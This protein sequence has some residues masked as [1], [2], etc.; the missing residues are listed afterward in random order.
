MSSVFVDWDD[1][2]AKPTPT[3][4]YSSVFDSAVPTVDR[5]DVGVR[6]LDPGASWAPQA[7][8]PEQIIVVKDG[9][10]EV[11][12]NG[13]AHPASAKDFVFLGA[14]ED[15]SITNTGTTAA[16]FHSIAFTTE[17][18][19]KVA[20]QSAG[21]EVMGSS[22]IRWDQVTPTPQTVLKEGQNVPWYRERRTF[23]PATKTLT[24]PRVFAHA[25]TVDP[26]SPSSAHGRHRWVVLFI[27][28][29]G[30]MEFTVEGVVHN[31]GPG[32]FFYMAEEAEHTQIPIGDDVTSYYVIH[33]SS[34][35]TP[36]NP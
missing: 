25:T 28:L 5:L 20:G 15:T 1:L 9:Q 4:S 14:G 10:L 22:V 32:S 26:G 7:G 18:T 29:E 12:I 33:V 34:A 31:S 21:G 35:T 23:V 3:G 11:S 27:M 19:G 36:L 30:T 16:T 24:S 13:A 6:T 17:L 8:G 2:R